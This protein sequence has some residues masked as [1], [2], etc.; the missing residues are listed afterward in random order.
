MAA[1]IPPRRRPRDGRVRLDGAA[2]GMMG[3]TVI[4][5]T[6]SIKYFA[7]LFYSVDSS[8]QRGLEKLKRIIV[9]IEKMPMLSGL[10]LV[11]VMSVFIYWDFLRTGVSF[12]LTVSDGFDQ[13]W[14]FLASLS[15]YIRSEGYP[16]WNFGIGLGS[17][18]IATLYGN[19]FLFIPI[20]LGRD[21]IPYV[22]VIMQICKI[23]FAFLFFYLFLKKLEF[24]IFARSTASILYAFC[25]IMITRGPWV[26]YGVECVI[27]AF[28]LY[29]MEVYLKNGKWHLVPIS[30]CLLSMSFGAYY[31]Y[32]Y[33][34]L[35]FIYSTTRYLYSVKFSMRT[36]GLY[37]FKIA[38]ICFLG[39]L[40]SGF[41]LLPYAFSMFS[42]FRFTETTDDI[43][44]VEYVVNLFRFDEVEVYLSEFY[45]FFSSDIL[46]VF[47]GYSGAGNYLEGPLFYCGL[48]NL[49]AIPQAFCFSNKKTGRLLTFGI[50]ASLAYLVF[51]SIHLLL[52][53]FI[54]GSFKLSSLW[55]CIIMLV[56][57][58]HTLDK[59]DK[60][61]ILN[62]KNLLFVF[63][64]LII[65]F[66]VNL[67]LMS[68]K[69]IVFFER[70]I[71]AYIVLFLSA[72]AAILFCSDKLKKTSL[73]IALFLVI[74]LEVCFFSH[75]SVGGQYEYA[76]YAGESYVNKENKK[77]YYNASD[78]VDLIKSIDHGFFRLEM[79]AKV[80]LN[81]SLFNEYY[82]SAYYNS[83]INKAY[84]EF[85]LSLRAGIFENSPIRSYSFGLLERP[86]LG[87]L[88][89]VKYRI[90]NLGDMPPFGFETLIAIV[91]DKAIYKNDDALPLAFVY[92][93][94]ILRDD[95]DNLDIPAKDIALF[96]AVVTEVS[97]DG[98]GRYSLPPR[99]QQI[100][101]PGFADSTDA[102]NG[103]WNWAEIYSSYDDYKDTLNIRKKEPFVMTR[104]SQN[105]IEGTIDVVGDRMLF[106][107]I[108]YSEGWKLTIDGEPVAM[109]KVN[110]GFIGAKIS[111]GKHIIKL[112]YFLPGLLTGVIMSIIGCAMFIVLAWN[113]ANISARKN[114]TKAL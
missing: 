34:I 1:G 104:F 57:T 99:I 43:S 92:D 83:F 7:K 69:G 22:M 35:I 109:E 12:L 59:I 2:W 111:T 45:R 50:S 78:A 64:L 75:I 39:V 67:Y 82:G 36:Y 107:S 61:T 4:K 8:C 14:P 112:D 40:M 98:L 72:Y 56:T 63:D 10:M 49:L 24:G 52:N 106:F 18:Y 6:N 28:I 25:G 46:G 88:V 32:L 19:P 71:S 53:G 41:I 79:N 13:T 48:L 37:I 31:V 73:L 55:I 44:I 38:G 95:F 89:G 17:P 3:L 113:T 11:L 16:M 102:E 90:M 70:E 103:E 81:D 30:I 60:G 87:A 110:V 86:L 108:P 101:R 93:E 97:R 27:A 9:F 47:E 114:S 91:D 58:A 66:V 62:K 15:D 54:G 77:G 51:P 65:G 21:A 5:T 94:Y 85:L 42:T 105:H 74:V 23:I 84:V 100:V 29:S 76:D 68:G 33:S 80:L 26:N 20:L 96:N